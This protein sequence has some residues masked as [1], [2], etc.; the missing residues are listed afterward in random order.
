MFWSS[1]WEGLLLF[2]YWQTWL[3]LILYAIASLAF[4]L[5]VGGIAAGGSDA[6]TSVG[7]ATLLIG[8]S[9][10]EGVLTALAV[11]VLIPIMLGGDS[12]LPIEA[13][14][15]LLWPAIKS[16]AIAMVVVLV[17]SVLPLIGRIVAEI[18]GVSS[19]LQ[20]LIVFRLFTGSFIENRILEAGSVPEGIYPGIFLSAG[21]LLTSMAITYILLM[22][23]SGVVELNR[24]QNLSHSEKMIED[25]IGIRGGGADNGVMV[26]IGQIALRMMGLLPLF[27]YASYT[28]MKVQSVIGMGAA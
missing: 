22:I 6:G 27:M 15:N 11:I 23:V 24:R 17:L 7:C 26:F 1:V 28:A 25:V 5:L 13:L 8:G 10:L 21:F 12:L 20:G 18:P 19:F 9:V 16:G 3:I 4:M 14:M 2:G